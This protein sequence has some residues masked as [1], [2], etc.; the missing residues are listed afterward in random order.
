MRIRKNLKMLP[1]KVV[2]ARTTGMTPKDLPTSIEELR[3]F[4]LNAI[5]SLQQLQHVRDERDKL[6]NEMIIAKQQT[7]ELTSTVEAQKKRLEQS[8]RTIKELLQALKGKKRERLDPN[9]L[10]LFELG[11]LEQLIEEATKADEAQSKDEVSSKSARRKKKKHG[12]RIIPDNLP[13]EVILHELPEEQRLCPIDGKPMP[14]IRY[15][16]SEQLDFEP[17]KL[18]RIQHKRA[19]YACPAKHDEATLITAPKPA[20]AI[21]RC[22]AAPGLLA[23]V[24]VG[25][26][27]DHLPGY[28]ME[29]I[30]SRGGVNLNRS[31]LYDWMAAAAD[32]TK[33]LYELMKQLVL[34]SK[35][36]QTD[37]T[38]VK[39]IDPLA[40]GGSRT[41]RFWAYLGDND[42]PFE[43]Y[44]FTV[45]RERHGPEEFLR[46]YSGYLQ[47]DAYGGYDG[48]YLKSSEKPII[49]VACWAH[50][51]RYWH[52]AR[53]ED[54]ARAHYVLA[55]ITKLYKVE[56][57]TRE[58]S[59]AARLSAREQV[60]RPLL[61]DLKLW[62]DAETFLPK[63][64]SGKAATYTLN[65][66]NA[67][68]R[69]LEDGDLS[70]DNN[71]SER[72]MRPVA[73]GRK[74]WMF[75]GSK[76]AGHRAAILMSMIATCKANLVEPWA[77][78]KDVLTQLPLGTPLESL[79]PNIWL[80][81]HPEHR[82]SI[83]ERRKLE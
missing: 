81:S 71:A 51:R 17:S 32:V 65:Q 61:N 66:W 8:E 21:E 78:L 72:A 42:H 44:D 36:I 82:W 26:F 25:K 67:L 62:L 3:Q 58:L 77:W 64:L 35:I 45:S 46:D 41:A 27:G 55:V 47:A 75:V 30:L 14:A 50:T 79:L 83:A 48:V 52:K 73:I 10:L 20:E 60:A 12:R 63:S 76:P 6:K 24:V 11:E 59:A 1:T 9:Q 69:Y 80:A 29:D 54:P 19:V 68:N 31:T 16:T 49:E 22:L 40:D 13:T 2:A 5:D 39:L 7:I 38:S 53:E 74:N 43:V 37:D 15:E 70:I 23:G 28:R 4:A 57:D 33:P 34:Q 18:K 56:S